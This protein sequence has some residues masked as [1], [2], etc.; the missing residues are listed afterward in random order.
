VSVGERSEDE[1]T[2]PTD[3]HL[4]GFLSSRES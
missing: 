1:R 2:W 4:P 3:L